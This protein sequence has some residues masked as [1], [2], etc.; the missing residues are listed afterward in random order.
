[1]LLRSSTF[2]VIARE[3][4]LSGESIACTLNHLNTL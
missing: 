4:T 1:M 3:V 2:Q